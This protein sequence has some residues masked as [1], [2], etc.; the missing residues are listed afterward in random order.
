MSCRLLVTR[1]GTPE[2]FVLALM[3]S[4]TVGCFGFVL[5]ANRLADLGFCDHGV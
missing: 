4:A 5:I 2:A 3:Y 1:V